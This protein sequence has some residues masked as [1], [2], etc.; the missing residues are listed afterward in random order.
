MAEEQEMQQAMQAAQAAGQ[1][2][3][4]LREVANIGERELAAAE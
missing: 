3:P 2:A 1:A 4:A